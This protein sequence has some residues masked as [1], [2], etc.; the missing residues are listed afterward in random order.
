M[1]RY[2]PS[3]KVLAASKAG[4]RPNKPRRTAARLRD[5]QRKALT[6]KVRRLV[7]RRRL[8]IRVAKVAARKGRGGPVV[9]VAQVPL[10]RLTDPETSRIAA[11]SSNRDQLSALVR[12]LLDAH[13]AG[14]SDWDLWRLTGRDVSE[15]PSVVNRR[16]EAG[17]VDTGLRRMSPSGRPC[18]VWTLA[19][20][21]R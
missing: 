9:T 4:H 14:L 6:P 17:C 11:E 5:Q 16:R 13:P 15:K 21:A 18:V 12:D 1:S 10:F 19:R 3:A 7:A 2:T 8:D 20:Y